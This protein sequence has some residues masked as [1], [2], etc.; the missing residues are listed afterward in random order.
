MR[1]PSCLCVCVSP[2]QLLNA[3]TYLP[4][5]WYVYYGN[6]SHLN[7]VLHKSLPSICMYACVSLMSLQGNG[8]VNCISPFGAKQ[9]LGKHVPTAT[10]TRND[11]RI[12]RRFIFYTV[13]VLTKESLWV[14]LCIPLSSLGKDSVKKFPKNFWRRRLLCVPYRIKGK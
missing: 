11:K 1:S 4:E 13:R 8:S 6:W 3:W 7:G 5:T 10:N 2:Y 12:V 9:R 14:F